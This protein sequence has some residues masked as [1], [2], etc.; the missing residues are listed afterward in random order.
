MQDSH[1]FFHVL[2]S[3]LCEVLYVST[4]IVHCR[5]LTDSELIFKENWTQLILITVVA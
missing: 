1:E 4:V 5:L 2:V 3:A